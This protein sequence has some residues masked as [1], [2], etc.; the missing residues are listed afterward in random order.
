MILADLHLNMLI[1]WDCAPWYN[2]H[3]GQLANC[4]ELVV[5]KLTPFAHLIQ[6]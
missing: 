3:M 6:G 2:K 5:K 4:Y 1:C